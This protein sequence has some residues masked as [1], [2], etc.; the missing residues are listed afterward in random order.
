MRDCVEWQKRKDRQGYG[1]TWHE[2]KNMRAHRLAW[3]NANGAIPYGM[4]V[5]HKCDNPSCVNPD[6]LFLGSR[7]ENNK[8]RASKGRSARHSGVK[9]P[10]AKLTDRQVI[11]IRNDPRTQAEIAIEHGVDQST[12]SNIKRRINWSHI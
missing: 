12:I 5:L 4:C 11:A 6:H 9:H 2:G 3:I 7:G 10:L 8:D 1:L